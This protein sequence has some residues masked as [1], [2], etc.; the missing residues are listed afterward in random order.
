MADGNFIQAYL[1]IHALIEALLRLFLQIPEQDR[2]SFSSLIQSYRSHMQEKEYPIPT[3]MDELTQFN[4][5]RNRIV[6]QL[7]R[8]GYSDTNQNTEEAARMAVLMYGLFIEWVQT[9][10]SGIEGYG[11][12]NDGGT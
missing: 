11:F 9:F 7:W 3:F 8:K 10:D 5:R 4:K 6:H 2:K 12:D 1:L